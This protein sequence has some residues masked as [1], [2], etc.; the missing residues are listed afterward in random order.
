MPFSVNMAWRETRTAW[1]HFLYFFVCIALGVAALVGVGLFADNLEQTV[2]REARSLMGGDLEVRLSH[3]LSEQGRAVLEGLGERGASVTHV[4][5]L[6]AMASRSNSG[7]PTAA[8]PVSS[9]IIELKAVEPAYPLYGTVQTT[10]TR[11]L[12]DLLAPDPAPCRVAGE[13]HRCY[14]AVVQEA[15]LIKMGLSVG[16]QFSI[17]RAWF[18]IRGTIAHEPDR[19]ASAFSLGPRVLVSQDALGAADLVKPGS[20]VR[21]RHLIR[22]PASLDAGQVLEEL[23]DRLAPDSARITAFRDA[24]PQLRRFLQQLDR[25]LGLIG[26]TALFVGGIGVA[27][28]IHAF[29]KEKLHTIAV[30]KTLG[31]DSKTIIRTYLFQAVTLGSIGSVAGLLIG[32]TVQHAMPTLLAGLFPQQLLELSQGGYSLPPAPLVRGLLL[33]IATT[34]LFTIWP[35]LGVRDVCPALIFRADVLALEARHPG[36][37]GPRRRPRR[38]RDA[39]RVVT[40]GA[41]ALGL[42]GVA[43]WQAE[44]VVIG[45]LFLGGLVAGAFLLVFAARFLVTAL[46]LAPPPGSLVLRH[47]FANLWRPG[48]QA[49]SITVAIGIGVMIIMTISI[50][51]RSLV[52]HIGDS[53]PIDAPTFFFIDIQP[54]QRDG[55]ERLLV[56]RLPGTRIDLTPLVRARLHAVNGRPVPLN[57]GVDREPDKGGDREEHGVS[58]YLTREYVLTFLEQLPKDNAILAGQWWGSGARPDQPLIS[59][60]EDA[61]RHLGVTVGSTLAFDIQGALVSGTVSSIR[62]VEWNNFST[63]FYMILS[64]GALEGAPFT[65]VATAR[66]SPGEQMAVQQAVVDAFPNVTAIN[67]GEVMGTFSRVLEH[68]SFAIRAIAGFCILAGAVVM[69]AALATTRYR[70]LYESVIFKALGATRNLIAGAFAAEYAVL[71]SVAGLIGTGLAA[72]LSWAILDSVFDLPWIWP[73]HVLLVGLALTI[74]LTVA[75][76]FLATYRI[77]GERPLSILRHE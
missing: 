33:G 73:V 8:G 64:P 16:D 30:L 26:L 13:E 44:S 10:P 27:T 42:A 24:Q 45:A 54:D 59:V 76:G 23:R 66:V 74:V 20:R 71:G 60:E 7:S 18:R 35:L 2:A 3:P 28:T 12:A 52:R 49:I 58:W 67:I 29:L 50:I 41:I 22:V 61:A 37:D 1:R 9:Q 14:G 72:G 75:V 43:M 5:E 19:I 15:L 62:K 38:P 39:V 53:R 55:V 34:L 56:E 70:R 17:G 65:Y 6:V 46:K 48:S 32:T 11:P 57:G 51:E 68:L 36:A 47:A 31:A 77:L 40:A 25:Y 63:N 69:A 4:S 21:E